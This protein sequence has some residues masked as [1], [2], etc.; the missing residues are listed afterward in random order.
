[1]KNLTFKASD[2]A[3]IWMHRWMPDPEQE[4]KGI[5][6]IHHGLAEHSLRYDRFGSIL[7]E[8]GYICNAYDMR[9]HG[10]T[11]ELAQKNGTGMLG[12]LADNDGF[13]RVVKDLSE[14]IASL[15]SEYSGKKVILFGHSFGSF[16]SQGFIENPEYAKLIDGCILCGTAGPRGLLVSFGKIAVSLVK[17]IQGDDKISPLLDKLAFGAYNNKIENQKTDHDWLTRDELT[18]QMFFSDK[19]CN[20]PLTNSFFGDM[21]SGLKMIH[22][23]ANIKK[24]PSDLPIFFVYGGADP[25]GDYGKTVKNLIKIYNKNGI[26]DLQSKEY[27]ED[28]HELLNELDKETVEADLLE[29]IS[30]H[31]D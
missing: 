22:N 2:G 23:S 15:K 7:A 26:K 10:Q 25:V 9:G 19:W 27:P 17:A 1:M 20:I 11:G 5:I 6:Q 30:R 3:E 14:I 29:W 4:I 21:M 31:L 13:N 12:K 8:N 18:V 16:I 28:R 24:I